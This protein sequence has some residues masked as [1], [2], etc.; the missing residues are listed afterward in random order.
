MNCEMTTLHPLIESGDKLNCKKEKTAS[1]AS[2]LA[3]MTRVITVPP[4]MAAVLVGA[5]HLLSGDFTLL[6]SAHFI[7]FLSVLPLMSYPVSWIVPSIRRKGRDGQ[8]KLATLVTVIGY[9]LLTVYC[10]IVRSPLREMI[11]CMTYLGS[12][13]M[14]AVLSYGFHFKSSGHTCGFSGPIAMLAFRVSPWSLLLYVL[15]VPVVWSSI[16]LRRHTPAQL[17]VGALIPVVI[18]TVLILCF[19]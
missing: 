16:R 15:I 14:T 3:A 13:I 10:L 2:I 8:R 9:V 4:F 7:F 19:G 11:I 18:M 5:M 1:P 12:G 6:S 17:L